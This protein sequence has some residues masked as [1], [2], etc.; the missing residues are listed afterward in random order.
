M[1]LITGATTFVGRAFLQLASQAGVAVRTL[2]RPSAKSPDLPPGVPVEVALTAL[3]DLRGVR[4]AMVGAR[5]VVHMAG[6]LSPGSRPQAQWIDVEGTRN[7]AEACAQAGV[8]RLLYLSH[9]GAEP[10]SAYPLMRAKAIAED[11][12]RRS[13]VPFTILRTAIVFGDGDDFTT[14][15]ARTVRG[16]PFVLPLPG[17]GSTILQPLWVEDLATSMMWSLDNPTMAG[18]TYEIGGPEYLSLREIAQLVLHA[19][20]KRRLIIKASPS[21]LRGL[22]WILERIMRRPPLTSAWMDYLTVNRVA[23][24]NTLPGVFGLQPARMADRLGYLA[25]RRRAP[26]G[27]GKQVGAKRGRP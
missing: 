14:G 25:P 10:L 21:A 26:R 27:Q 17:E 8:E 24:L 11:H 3:T 12:I 9:V 15:L 6:A 22:A 20:G 1:L 18:E 4:A 5:A 19:M 16:L 23:A 13:G 2:L 7:L